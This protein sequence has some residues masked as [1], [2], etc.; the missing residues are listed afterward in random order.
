MSENE[1]VELRLGRDG[2]ASAWKILLPAGSRATEQFHDPVSIIIKGGVT[3]LGQP[4]QSPEHP[5]SVYVG[6][7]Q[8]WVDTTAVVEAFVRLWP[9]ALR[10]IAE[11]SANTA[12]L[13][14]FAATATRDDLY[15]LWPY[16]P[17][18]PDDERRYFV[19][20]TCKNSH[21][22]VPACGWVCVE[23][24]YEDFKRMVGPEGFG[25]RYGT[26]IMGI[27]VHEAK[28]AEYLCLDFLDKNALELALTGDH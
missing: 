5:M 24:A 19:S 16:M 14:Y 11:L 3:T 9:E 20:E 15:S 28:A 4:P 26:T 10:S 17:L 25:F 12:S 2:R 22:R 8:A 6:E 27:L 23:Y 7:K 18:G 21:T 13:V 1:V